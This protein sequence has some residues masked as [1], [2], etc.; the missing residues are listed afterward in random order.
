MHAL[1]E[2]I[3]GTST[4]GNPGNLP[5]YPELVL[6][7]KDSRQTN[8]KF[9]LEAYSIEQKLRSFGELPEGWDFGEGSPPTQEII[10]QAIDI[11]KL[12]KTY[13]LKCEVFAIGEGEIEVSL[14]KGEQFFDILIRNDTTMEFTYEFGVGDNYEE[15]ENIVNISREEIEQKLIN[16]WG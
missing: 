16:M 5:G 10:E 14:F 3:T 6:E 12:G 13:D 7:K 2:V 9:D 15:I 1:A 8:I 4:Q 11:F